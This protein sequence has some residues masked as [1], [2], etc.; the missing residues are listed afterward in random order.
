MCP[1]LL[2]IMVQPGTRRF[3]PDFDDPEGSG[4]C[5]GTRSFVIMNLI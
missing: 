5:S 2:T 4:T 1:E 3:V